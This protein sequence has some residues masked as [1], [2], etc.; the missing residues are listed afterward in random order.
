M[1]RDFLFLI[2][3][4]AV[5]GLSSTEPCT[6]PYDGLYAIMLLDFQY[7]MAYLTA[8]LALHRDETALKR[9]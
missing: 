4:N 8:K 2:D 3:T 7:A 5:P 1:V 9:D 6:L